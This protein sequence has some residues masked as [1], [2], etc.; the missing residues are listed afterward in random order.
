[1]R[2]LWVFW[3]LLV[4]CVV[5]WNVNAYAHARNNHY[6]VTLICP[7]LAEDSAAHVRMVTYVPSSDGHPV[8]VYRCMR[9]G[10]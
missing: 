7:Q 8:I 2:A 3:V 4:L 10:Y 1:M 5:A 9:Y 6:A